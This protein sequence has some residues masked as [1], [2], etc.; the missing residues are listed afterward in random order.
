MLVL[1]WASTLFVLSSIPGD[2]YPDVNVP[3]SDKLAH[4]CL[5]LPFGLLLG[6]WFSPAGAIS[7]AAVIAGTLYAASDEL[8][9]I[10]VTNRSCSVADWIVDV[11]SILAGLTLWRLLRRLPQF[12]PCSESLQTP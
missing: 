2:R 6:R 7:I 8:H 3:N 11:F 5:Y 4:I 10:F 1:L 12:T 9:Q